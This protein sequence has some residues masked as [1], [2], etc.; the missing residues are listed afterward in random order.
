MPAK[1]DGMGVCD[2]VLLAALARASATAAGGQRLGGQ[3][4]NTWGRAAF[5]GGSRDACSL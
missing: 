2:L 1:P 5:G 4:L 3:S